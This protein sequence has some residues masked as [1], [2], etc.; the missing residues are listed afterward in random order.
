MVGAA[1]RFLAGFPYSEYYGSPP[2]C[3][4]V[5][6]CVCAGWLEQCHAA[7]VLRPS[8]GGG[9]RGRAM[10]R[11]VLGGDQGGDVEARRLDELWVESRPKN[12]KETVHRFCDLCDQAEAS[13]EIRRLAESE[14]ARMQAVLAC[15]GGP[16]RW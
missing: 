15:N 5:P 10:D 11:P 8:D 13:G 14:P 6:L 9:A 3:M 4:R 2:P 7:P 1:R 16:T 12:W